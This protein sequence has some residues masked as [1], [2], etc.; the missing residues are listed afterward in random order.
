MSSQALVGLAA[1]YLDAL[2]AG[3]RITALLLMR[4][5][6]SAGV[7]LCDLYQVVL[8]PALYEIGRLWQLGQLDV[9]SEHLATA[10]TRSAMELCSSKLK[11]LPSGPPLVLATCVGSE[12]HDLGLR[13]V[14]DCL[15]VKGW[16]TLYLGSNMPID[17]IVALAVQHRVA[18]VAASITIG[19]HARF[20]RDLV[21]ALRQSVIGPRVKILVGGQPFNRLP[22]L[23]RQLGADGTAADASGAVAWIA[24]QLAPAR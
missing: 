20:V 3:D 2:R 11:P 17:A 10:I 16:N 15:E 13:M 18:V 19:S 21:N 22:D 8:Q 1:D 6:L 7:G 5:A 9:A 4:E 24:G 14:S 12:L 23:W